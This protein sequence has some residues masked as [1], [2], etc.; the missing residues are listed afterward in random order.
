VVIV[1]HADKRTPADGS[2]T[3]GGSVVPQV[4]G[5]ITYRPFGDR[6][7]AEIAFCAVAQSLQ[8]SGYGTRL[9]NWTKA[10]PPSLPACHPASERAL[11][12]GGSL[13]WNAVLGCRGR[14]RRRRRPG[15]GA[16]CPAGPPRSHLRSEPP[17]PQTPTHPAPPPPS[18]LPPPPF[19]SR[20]VALCTRARRLR[21]LP[22]LR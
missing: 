9:M 6:R 11:V 3:G 19:P 7:F 10:S 1:R 15:R 12:G 18:P 5:G 16:A 14:Q 8:V 21:V 20:C 22:D 13:C 4:I 2:A 17:P